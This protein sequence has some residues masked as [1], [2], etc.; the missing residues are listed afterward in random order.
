MTAAQAS[1][2]RDPQRGDRVRLGAHAKLIGKVPLASE[3]TMRIRVRPKR[4]TYRCRYSAA[5]P[6]APVPTEAALPPPQVPATPI[7]ARVSISRAFA[8]FRV[9]ATQVVLLDMRQPCP[10]QRPMPRP[11]HGCAT[12][13]HDLGS[14]RRRQRHLGIG[15]VGLASGGVPA[16]G[17]EPDA[18][19]DF[20]QKIRQTIS[21]SIRI[22]SVQSRN[23]TSDGGSSSSST[24]STRT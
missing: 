14:E 20:Q 4:T 5:I 24:T 16:F 11:H 10:V 7:P 3:A 1:P 2:L 9:S 19:M 15:H 13:V 17:Q 21:D 6:I 18:G 23:A 12:G 22:R 8:G